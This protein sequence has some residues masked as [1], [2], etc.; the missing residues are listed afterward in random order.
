MR[1]LF[2]LFVIICIIIICIFRTTNMVVREG[3]SQNNLVLV[4]DSILNNAPYVEEDQTVESKLL[5]ITS[6][7]VFVLAKDRATIH[8]VYS[9]L[10]AI[11][12]SLNHDQNS[13]V[14]SVGGNNLLTDMLIRQVVN[15]PLIFNEYKK[16]V[17]SIRTSNFKARLFVMD[18]YYPISDPISDTFHKTIYHWNALL[19][20]FG[21]KE[22]Y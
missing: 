16:L 12:H 10:G 20:R 15:V 19:Y 18:I 11:P 17:L 1:F 5:Q 3:F 13:I 7:R 6:D 21:E 2:I 14:L 8:D 9:Q 4:G 22:K